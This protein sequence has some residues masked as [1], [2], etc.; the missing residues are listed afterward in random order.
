MKKFPHYQK[1]SG[2][3][4]FLAWF[5]ALQGIANSVILLINMPYAFDNWI[6]VIFL[7]I[8]VV[9]ALLYFLSAWKIVHY[10]ISGFRLAI[11]M[12][13]LSVFQFRMVFLSGVFFEWNMVIL[14]QLSFVW[15]GLDGTYF[16]I[17]FAALIFLILAYKNIMKMKT[18][19]HLANPKIPEN[20]I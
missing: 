18:E 6:S 7:I 1:L 3:G 14:L 19:A 5:L 20:Q 16:K 8:E 12:F 9:F 13:V 2:S 15:G 10:K 11:L 4:K 17:N